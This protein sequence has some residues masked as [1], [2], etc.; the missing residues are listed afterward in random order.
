MSDHKD[1]KETKDYTTYF[2]QYHH[3]R[4]AFLSLK[5]RFMKCKGCD[6]LKK[7]TENESEL[8]YS[9]GSKKGECGDQFTIH[10]PEYINYRERKQML[11]EEINGSM[12]DYNPDVNDLSYINLK[13]LKNIYDLSNLETLP[14]IREVNK[15][16]YIS[17]LKDLEQKYKDTNKITQ[18][19]EEGI[20]Y[21]KMRI[22]NIMEQ[23][24]ILSQLQ[25]ATKEEKQDLLI[26]YTSLGKEIIQSYKDL[27]TTIHKP[28]T[29]FIIEEKATITKHNEAY[30]QTKAK[31]KAKE[32]KK[33][34]ETEKEIDLTKLSNINKKKYKEGDKVSF[35]C[36]F[37]KDI[38][39]GTI[40]R[41]NPKR[42]IVIDDFTK[43]QYLLP[44]HS[45]YEIDEFDT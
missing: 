24:K 43:K 44:Y 26:R 30:L 40:K 33:E 34:K 10:L 3:D 9:C 18:K 21:H 16:T 14:T 36:N 25:E 17:D 20:S 41:K 5:E 39:K 8:K 27:Q 2:H 29:N 38:C 12:D 32:T 45:L 4:L 11:H 28:L 13:T 7:F 35:K 6:D 1:K 15:E 22:N 42:A 19:Y 31:A 23:K 37:K